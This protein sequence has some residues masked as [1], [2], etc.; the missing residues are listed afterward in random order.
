MSNIFKLGKKAPRQD[1]RTFQFKS[2][3]NT[4]P[5]IPTSID[6]T[7]KVPDWGM[8]GNDTVGDCTCAGAGHLEM[9]WSSQTNA[10]TIPTT[11]QIL[12]AYSAITGYTPADP[13]TDTGADLLTVLN[14]WRA[15]PIANNSIKAYAQLPLSNLADIRAAIALFGG[16]YMGVQLPDNAEDAFSNGQPWA[17]TTDNNIEGGHCIVLVGY[18]PQY[19][20][21]ITWGAKQLLTPGWFT[22]YADEAYAVMSPQWFNAN[23]TAPSG[24]NLAQL[25]ADLQL[26]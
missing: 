23:G 24:F 4:L 19:F 22:R 26:L 2:Y 9:T 15:N 1:K 17:D 11:P 13:N 18:T 14:Y 21:A 16:V 10:E 20:T 6:W 25:E 12:T 3:F 5:P 7:G 8:L